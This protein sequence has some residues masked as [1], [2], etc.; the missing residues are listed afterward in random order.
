V[1]I[2]SNDNN[3]D[4]DDDDDDGTILLLV[5]IASQ[6]QSLSSEFAKFKYYISIAAA[7]GNNFILP[8]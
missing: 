4:D 8:P 2:D 7:A 1:I 3:D 6:P 5:P